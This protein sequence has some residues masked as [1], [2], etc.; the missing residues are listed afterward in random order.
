MCLACFSLVCT[1]IDND[2]RRH[3]GQNAVE[4]QGQPS[5]SITCRLSGPDWSIQISGEAAVCKMS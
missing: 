5:E 1:L 2:T 3:S 4:S